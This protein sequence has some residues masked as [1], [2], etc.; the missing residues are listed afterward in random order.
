M[1]TAGKQ[2]E[3]FSGQGPYGYNLKDPY[4]HPEK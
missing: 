1:P 3:V 2:T 4:H